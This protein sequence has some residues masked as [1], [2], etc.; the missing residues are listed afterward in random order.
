[1]LDS[2]GFESKAQICKRSVQMDTWLVFL[3]A[4]PVELWH[5]GSSKMSDDVL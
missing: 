4:D 1:M 5:V 2:A 3:S